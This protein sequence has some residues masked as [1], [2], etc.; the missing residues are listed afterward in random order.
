MCTADVATLTTSNLSPQSANIIFMAVLLNMYLESLYLWLLHKLLM[1][2]VKANKKD[3]VSGFMKP[4]DIVA[5]TAA[6]VDI[7]REHSLQGYMDGDVYIVAYSNVD[8]SDVSIVLAVDR[9]N[10]SVA[11]GSN[12]IFYHLLLRPTVAKL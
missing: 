5:D 9:V 2:R 3:A 11:A 1:I 12:S 4:R 10:T 7:V 6:S 8:D